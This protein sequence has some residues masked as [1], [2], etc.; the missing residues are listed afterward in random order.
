MALG[1]ARM[2]ANPNV[3]KSIGHFLK[4]GQPLKDF[5][6]YRIAPDAGFAALNAVQTPGGL[7]DKLIAGITDFGLSAGSGLVAG[8]AA[9]KFGADQGLE[10]LVDMF[11]S[12][13][14]AMASYPAGM[15]LTRAADK[16]TGGPGLTDF[17]KMQQKDQQAYVDQ[18]RQEALAAAG[19]FPGTNPA[20]YGQSDYLT[21]LGLA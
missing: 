12:Y 8:G 15:A 10:N 20:Y 3:L 2:A 5:L 4:G 6:L 18:I 14:G 19:Y 21:Q 17:E 7:D 1:I 9:R 16:M 13:G 11:A